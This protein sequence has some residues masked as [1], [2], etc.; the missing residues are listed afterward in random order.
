MQDTETIEVELSEPQEALLACR[1]VD[2]LNM[3]GQGGGK[4][5]T[6][7]L[8]SGI[9]ISLFPRLRGF[10]GANTWDQLNT[11]T[12][13]AVLEVWRT[14]YGF[15]EYSKE[16]PNG[17]YVIDKTPPPHFQR[18]V[19]LPKYKN[20]ISFFSGC[21]VFIGS[22]DN[23]MAQDGKE[24]CWAELDETKDT[25]EKAVKEVIKGRLRQPGLWY[26]RD[27]TL[28]YGLENKD[29]GFST[30]EVIARGLTAWNPLYI[31]TS[32]ASG[33]V[34]WVNE[35]FDLEAYQQE[36]LD[37][38]SAGAA[39]FFY[40]EN[41]DKK[42]C[43]IVSSAYHNAHN[44]ARGYLENR[45]ALFGPDLTLKLIHG[46][47]FAKV[48]G[49]YIHAFNRLTHVRPV[50]FVSGLP[51]HLT[52]DFNV[53]PY[54]TC[55]LSQIE[56]VGRYLHPDGKQ[57]ADQ[58]QIGWTFIDVMQ[59]RFYREYCL[60]SPLNTTAAICEKFKEE[61]PV[62]TEAYYYGDATGA[63]RKPGLGSYTDYG[64]IEEMLWQYFHNDSRRVN[65]P[66]IAPGQRRDLLNAIFAGN[67]PGV[68]IIIDPSCTT[69]IKDLEQVKLGAA[70]KLKTKVKDEETGEKYEAMGHTGD[71]MEY[72]VANICVDYIKNFQ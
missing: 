39:D 42:R 32:P 52:W 12:L 65:V 31:H 69:L 41:K 71:A 59:I 29:E 21:L 56:Y 2:I 28:V 66:N 23:Y 63:A 13:K 11:A 3:A 36:I 19:K 48:G 46:Y 17:T 34:T 58:P 61:T 7:G 38:V 20:T 27:G 30:E 35:W 24:Y 44:L 22:L 72:E 37:K 57:K 33:L 6:I 10:I 1:E 25:E 16:N 5:H 47:P 18:F 55:L 26:E 9:K 70:G 60:A 51:V 68:E 40:K 45:A 62:G 43:A 54:M 4:S 64:A 50:V 53:V 15:T 8:S 67:I 14:V 49:T